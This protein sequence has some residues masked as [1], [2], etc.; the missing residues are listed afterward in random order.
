MPLHV[1]VWVCLCTVYVAV[2]GFYHWDREKKD[3]HFPGNYVTRV[4]CILTN[5]VN[6]CIFFVNYSWYYSNR[7]ISEC[8]RVMLK[9]AEGRS[10]LLLGIRRTQPVSPVVL[11]AGRHLDWDTETLRKCR[12]NSTAEFHRP[13]CQTVNRHLKGK[14]GS[15]SIT[16]AA[17]RQFHSDLYC[18]THKGRQDFK[19][20]NL[21]VNR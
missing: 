16:S 4:N 11:T 1:C 19:K 17:T 3:L 10:S 9:P 7:N 14:A 8:E 2:C 18:R 21:Q 6:L 5:Y 12:R 13:I 20:R 15:I